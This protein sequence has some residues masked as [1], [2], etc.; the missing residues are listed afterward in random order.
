MNWTAVKREELAVLRADPLLW[1]QE[2][3]VRPEVGHAVAEAVGM[4]AGRRYWRSGHD[5]LY[6]VE[7][8]DTG[9]AEP[10]MATVYGFWDRFEPRP[11]EHEITADL[12]EFCCWVARVSPSLAEADVRKVAQHA[13]VRAQWP[14]GAV[15]RT[16]EECF[17]A[18]PDYDYTPRYV[19]V[20]G[21]RMAY[22][23]HGAGAPIL[24]LHGEPTWG[25]LYRKMIPTLA[26][27]GR[28]IVPDLI[29]FGRSDK[30]V[31]ANAFTY[32]SHARWLRRF[33]EALDLRG[34][35]L[36]CQDWGGLLGLR[37]LAQ[38]PERFGRLAA[39]N[40]GLPTGKGASEA[41]LK[42]RRF[43]QS[44]DAFDLPKLMQ[45]S[46]RRPAPQVVLDAYGAPFPSAEYQMAALTF[47]RLVPIR[48]DYP[49]ALENRRAL[50]VLRTLELPVLLPWAEGDAITLPSRE[51][52][53][54]TFRNVQ[55]TPLIADA[56][57]FIQE[58]AGEELAG[59]IADWMA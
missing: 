31:A 43:S 35:T 28:V 8:A 25:F 30:P 9:R 24:C 59:L 49:G 5:H 26:A 7:L 41:F 34:V 37:V 58:D 44:V 55:G 19:D 23:E 38:M 48:P 56:G 2:L 51:H 32:K 4:R 52:L 12:L 54:R 22:V 50:D 27:K 11:P 1:E 42:W 21:L 10:S 47:P 40:T 17:A 29:G 13:D 18:V 16:P 3:D 6:A 46:L 33:V 14:A 53:Q 20:E 39:F 57:H 15:L 36:L 45:R